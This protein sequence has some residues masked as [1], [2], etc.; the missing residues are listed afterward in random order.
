MFLYDVLD[1]EP[2]TN[3]FA[4]LTFP[5]FHH[6]PSHTPRKFSESKEAAEM[7]E[8]SMDEIMTFGCVKPDFW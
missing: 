1:I 6:K 2:D 5:E 8:M 3:A 4:Q 7:C